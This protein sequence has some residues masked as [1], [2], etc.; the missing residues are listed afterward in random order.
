MLL[1]AGA[2]DGESMTSTESAAFELTLNA[3]CE[4]G[5]LFGNALAHLLQ[6]GLEMD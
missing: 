1:F 3:V 6:V 2:Q 4:S 5:H